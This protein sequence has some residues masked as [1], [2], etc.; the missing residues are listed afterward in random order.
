MHE[1]F[2]NGFAPTGVGMRL[3]LKA[4]EDTRVNGLFNPWTLKVSQLTEL[5]H[6]ENNTNGILHE[7]RVLEPQIRAANA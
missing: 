3:F 2:V 1:I 7:L 6:I 5:Q 4:M